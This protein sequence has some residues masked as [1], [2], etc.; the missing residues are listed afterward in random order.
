MQ[1]ESQLNA[2]TE[3]AVVDALADFTPYTRAK[4]E[5]TMESVKAPSPI[6]F[7]SEAAKLEPIGKRLDPVV[8]KAQA[9]FNQMQGLCQHVTGVQALDHDAQKDDGSRGVAGHV[10][11]QATVIEKKLDGVLQAISTIRRQL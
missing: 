1:D 5:R 4:E 11:W 2:A 8:A 7:R 6:N 9:V 3:S 10:D